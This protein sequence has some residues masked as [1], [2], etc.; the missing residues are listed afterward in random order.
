[1]SD[2]SEHYLK[3]TSN[4]SERVKKDIVW[5]TLEQQLEWFDTKSVSAKCWH[6]ILKTFELILAVSIP[7]LT[8]ADWSWGKW[9]ISV[10][11]ALIALLE[12]IQYLNQFF[13]NWVNYRSVAQRLNGERLLFLSNA[14][15]YKDASEDQNLVVLAEKLEEILSSEQSDW[16]TRTKSTLT[17]KEKPR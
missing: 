12:G 9:V 2:S 6:R 16:S 13:A 3:T 17:K 15:H 11:G 8:H 7:V 10:V 4:V 14:R 5:I 1:M